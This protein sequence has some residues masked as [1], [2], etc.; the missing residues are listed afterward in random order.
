MARVDARFAGDEGDEGL[1][2][3]VVRA[4]NDS[5][6][7]DAWMADERAFDFGGADAMA[8]DVEDVV[9]A[10]DDPEVTVFVLAAAVACEI[11]ARDFSPIDLL[12]IGRA[13]V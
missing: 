4:S 5:R 13:H 9:D 1:A 6:F 3:E 7:G 2:F 10:A 12:E 8:G 11:G